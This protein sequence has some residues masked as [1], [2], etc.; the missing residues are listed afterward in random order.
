[1]KIKIIALI[2]CLGVLSLTALSQQGSIEHVH[3]PVIA[4][5][6]GT[7]WIF[8]TGGKINVRHSTNL[9]DWEFYGQP[10]DEL[11]KWAKQ[12][13][14]SAKDRWA[15]DIS[16]FNNQYHLYYSVSTF[17]SNRSCIG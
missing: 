14:P 16:F 6:N 12:H 2:F 11:P 9:V 4:K 17:G 5:A 10:L 3:D 8:S 15:P 13:V 1:M 7:F